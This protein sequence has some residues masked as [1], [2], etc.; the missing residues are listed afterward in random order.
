MGTTLMMHKL[1]RLQF[2]GMILDI[3]NNIK[4]VI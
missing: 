1:D 3:S 4:E 2:C